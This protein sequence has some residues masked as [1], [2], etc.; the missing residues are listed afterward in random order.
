MQVSFVEGELLIWLL[1]FLGL[2][3]IAFSLFPFVDKRLHFLFDSG[4]ENDWLFIDFRDDSMGQ[5]LKILNFSKNAAGC[6][7]WVDQVEAFNL[8]DNY[9]FDQILLRCLAMKEVNNNVKFH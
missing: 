9:L 3:A 7:S 2:E 1:I 8:V 4:V 5:V 6:K